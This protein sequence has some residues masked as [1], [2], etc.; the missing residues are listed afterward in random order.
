MRVHP[1]GTTVTS[2]RSE[3]PGPARDRTGAWR[4]PATRSFRGERAVQV[5]ARTVHVAA[6]GLLLGGVAY[7]V[8]QSRLGLPIALTLASGLILFGVDLWKGGAYLV[9]GNGV[10][11]LLKLA[12]LG[13][14]QFLPGQRL[15][16]YLAATVV[17]SV[18]SHMPRTWRH[19][20]FVHRRVLE[21][22]R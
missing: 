4:P 12:L 8:P 17:A 1:G 10:A 22:H 6:M 13:M 18:G 2:I 11:V 19:W 16:W 15:E 9:Q 7:A 14:G 20:S 5:A 21:D 3:L